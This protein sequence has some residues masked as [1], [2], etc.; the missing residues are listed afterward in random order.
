M[1]RVIGGIVASALVLTVIGTAV[2][3]VNY[4]P[5]TGGFAGKGD[6]QNAFG[7]KNAAMQANY[8]GVTFEYDADV[9]HSFDCEWTTGPTH[10]RITHRVTETVSSPVAG[11]VAWDPKRTGQFTGFFLGPIGGANANTFDPSAGCGGLGAGKTYVEDT[12]S[13]APGEGSGLFAIHNDDRRQ[14]H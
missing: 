12:Y 11:S 8:S 10:N 13:S 7:W 3:A 1:K 5:A 14:I 2:A 6:V 4:D 9:V